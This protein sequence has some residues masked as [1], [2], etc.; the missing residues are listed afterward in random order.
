MKFHDLSVLGIEY[1]PEVK[2][3]IFL[4]INENGKKVKVC[5]TDVV[6]WSF[7]PFTSQN[8][9]FDINM[10]SKDYIPEGLF[11]DYEVHS[12]YRNYINNDGY[13]LFEL[14]SSVG[15]GGYII[16]KEIIYL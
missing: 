6:H 5:F 10:Y 7:S 13:C 12:Y 2:G 4:L 15:M 3:I 11:D 1:V 16:A 8:V 9:L 14:D